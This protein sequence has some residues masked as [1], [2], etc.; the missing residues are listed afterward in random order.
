MLFLG[1]QLRD[2]GDLQAACDCFQQALERPDALQRFRIG[3]FRTSRVALPEPA[4]GSDPSDSRAA[5]IAAGEPG[6]R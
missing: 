6:N 2:K 5:R 3:D 1:C 4:G